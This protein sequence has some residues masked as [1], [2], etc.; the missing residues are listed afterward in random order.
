MT[1]RWNIYGR[2][3]MHVCSFYMTNKQFHFWYQVLTCRLPKHGPQGNPL[4]V[5][6]FLYSSWSLDMKGVHKNKNI[7]VKPWENCKF[8]AI[9]YLIDQKM[10]KLNNIIHYCN[11]HLQSFWR[12]HHVVNVKL[13]SMNMVIISRFNLQTTPP[14]HI[15]MCDLKLF[16]KMFVHNLSKPDYRV[17]CNQRWRKSTFKQ[18]ILQWQ[19]SWIQSLYDWY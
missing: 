13:Y 12:I 4:G 5:L 7:F 19:I 1:I 6:V 18:V 10:S 16:P 15:S 2:C 3:M 17:C 11:F 14:Q 8:I 9:L